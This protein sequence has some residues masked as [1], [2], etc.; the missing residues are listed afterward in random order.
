MA[1]YAYFRGRSSGLIS[2]LE[3][4]ATDVLTALARKS[5]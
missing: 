2:R 5:A 1:F 3:A 4:A